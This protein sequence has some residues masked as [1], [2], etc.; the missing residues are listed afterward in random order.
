MSQSL[1]L[2]E[3]FSSSLEAS[4]RSGMELVVF[5]RNIHLGASKSE[6]SLKNFSIMPEES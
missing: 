6:H 2:L 1:A 5:A 4:T 3:T